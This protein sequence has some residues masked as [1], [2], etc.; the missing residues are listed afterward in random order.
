MFKRFIICLSLLFA[1][2]SYGQTV[3]PIKLILT[4]LDSVKNIQTLRVTLKSLERINGV[5]QKG[6]SVDKIQYNPKKIY[7]NN[8]ARK[9]E[10]LCLSPD[11]ALVKPGTF[12]YISINLDPNGSTMR[13]NQHYTINELGFE[14]VGIAIA[15]C[16]NKEKSAD[17]GV[18]YHGKQKK[19]EFNCY[20]FEYNATNFTYNEYTV[21]AKETVTSIANKFQVSD[22]LIRTKNDLYTDYGY[23]KS[24]KKILIPSS[25]SKRVI[26]YIDEKSMLPICIN[27]FDEVGLFE[28][29]E[30]VDFTVNKPISPEEF[31]KSYPGYGF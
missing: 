11:K 3:N 2:G 4:M 10:I 25:Y 13:K 15:Y 5:Y 21:G 14:F 19:G 6:E 31:T 24:G 27:S 9:V 30:F 22:Y 16:L 12:P 28:C 17:K 26:F 7:F 18:V 1:F 29:Y 20:M 8:K 23:L